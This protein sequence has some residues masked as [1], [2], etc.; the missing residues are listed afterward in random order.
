MSISVETPTN[1]II[2]YELYNKDQGRLCFV[3]FKQNK[4][5]F[6]GN[7]DIFVNKHELILH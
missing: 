2:K 3:N 4:I 7:I 6:L 1:I 5:H